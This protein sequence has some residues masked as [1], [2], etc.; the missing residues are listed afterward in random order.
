MYYTKYIQNIEK[1]VSCMRNAGKH[2]RKMFDF[3]F[4]FGR[5]RIEKGKN[6]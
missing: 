2:M 1:C 4:V 5:I 3:R 6:T